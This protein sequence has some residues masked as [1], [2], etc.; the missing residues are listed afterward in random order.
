MNADH[1][2]RPRRLARNTGSGDFDLRMKRRL[3]TAWVCGALAAATLIGWLPWFATGPD[4]FA[5][6]Q[7]A[8]GNTAPA[9]KKA[10][11]ENPAAD[12]PPAGDT[13][14]AAKS[15]E[16][17]DPP[18]EG[19]ENSLAAA[20]EAVRRRYKR[21]E[22]TLVKLSTSLK[23][24]DPERAAL[25]DRAR[26]RLNQD[27]VEY[28][29][30][31]IAK[32]LASRP[33][34]DTV[35]ERES[36]LL[37]RLEGVLE[38]LQSED[39]RKELQR[40]KERIQGLLQDVNRLISDQKGVRQETENRAPTGPLS[41]KQQKV[42]SNAGKLINKIDD[43]DKQRKAESAEE[44]SNGSPEQP[45]SPDKE[46]QTPETGDESQ[47]KKGEGNDSP[48]SPKGKDPQG[49]DPQADPAQKPDSEKE[50]A[51][52]D[53]KQ[54]KPKSDKPKKEQE[55]TPSGEKSPS[56]PPK[57][58]GDAES[59]SPS[60]KPSKSQPQP[61]MPG[62]SQPMPGQ[63][64]ESESQP[65]EQQEQSDQTPGREQLEQARQEMERAIEELKKEQR[66]K[67]SERQDEAVRKLLEAKEK[68]EEILRQLREEEKARMLAS[69]E[70]RFQRILANE[71][72]IY[73]GTIKLAKIEH[74]AWE[75][76]HRSQSRELS[77]QQDDV[78]LDVQKAMTLLKEEG[79]SV[80]FPEAVGQVRDDMRT[81]SGRLANED[82]G[83]LTTAIEQDII[84]S[85]KEMIE[86]LQK[87]IE[88]QREKANE[89][90]KPG[91]QGQQGDQ[92]LVDQI[93]E[94]KMLRGLQLRINHRTK[95]LGRMVQGEQT[96]DPQLI[97]QLR[98]LGQ[99]QA[100]IQQATY[101][102]ATGRNK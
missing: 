70:A 10:D 17:G 50:K 75:P 48:E 69:L 89:P 1:E 19:E 33:L 34:G 76:K 45:Q 30:A 40:E 102:L 53:K 7:P 52:T 94:L 87:E 16:A 100:R 38:L 64:G 3:P 15:A 98:T 21:L 96:E 62:Q 12:A 20:Q 83:E 91:Q 101:D 54:G 56:Q 31:E 85:L 99:R 9:N 81:V 32:L 4:A 22:E 67:A 58:D 63:Q 11:R 43:Q 60:G 35:I 90:P 41:E 37:V 82:A 61:P 65:G 80:A 26:G 14:D 84:D 44:K 6:E 13:T 77:Q 36:E 8:A 66:E 88:K 71:L 73:D 92:D 24:T 86:A 97:E 55:P 68:L 95:R 74:A 23:K 29:M 49:D 46:P 79:S 5:Q 18:A 59:K 42:T 51:G 93:A 28:E 72:K 57:S 25:M 27:R 78:I 39:R 2:Q 47:G